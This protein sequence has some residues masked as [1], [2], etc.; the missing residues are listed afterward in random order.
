MLTFLLFYFYCVLIPLLLSNLLHMG[1]VKT[2]RLQALAV[3]ISDKWLGANKTWRGV[4]V[5]IVCNACFTF[6]LWLVYPH[7]T[8]SPFLSFAIGGLLGWSYLMGE[9]PNSFIKRRIGI[10]PGS[11]D[12][13]FVTIFTDK[14]DSSLAVAL[15]SFILLHKKLL[16]FP[17][18]NLDSFPTLGIIAVLFAMNFMT[19]VFFSLL[20]V[21]LKIKSSF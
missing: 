19:H 15:F 5:M 1:V 9:L 3:P 2:K 8:T 17:G 6:L 10:A 21:K 11:K 4:W 14:S 13:N 16:L 12:R 20:F 18:L 7:F